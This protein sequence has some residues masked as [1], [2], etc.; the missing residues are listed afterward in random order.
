MNT[1]N[2]RTNVFGG[3]LRLK[4]KDGR[5][6]FLE[7]AH[8]WTLAALRLE[9]VLTPD[10]KQTRLPSKRNAK[11]VRLSQETRGGKLSGS[12]RGD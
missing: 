4:R 1:D 12:G 3:P 5:K 10:P 6:A 11:S 9:G 7:L 2:L 8:D